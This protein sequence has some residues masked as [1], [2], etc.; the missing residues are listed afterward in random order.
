MSFR[1]RMSIMRNAYALGF[2]IPGFTAVE[3]DH[4]C[5]TFVS[6]VMF[7][8]H[9]SASITEDDSS[10]DD[11]PVSGSPCIHAQ[12]GGSKSKVIKCGIRLV[13][14]Q[15]IED[16][17]ELPAA[18][19]STFHQNHNCSLPKRCTSWHR[20]FMPTKSEY[21]WNIRGNYSCLGYSE[22]DE[23]PDLD[24]KRRR[25]EHSD[26]DKEPEYSDCN[27]RRNYSGSGLD[28]PNLGRP[29]HSD[30]DEEPNLAK[31][32]RTGRVP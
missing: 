31:K 23:E 19:G 7:E 5:L 13:Y 32:S 17:Q 10:S 11:E 29:E 9:N 3:S 8:H 26:R 15:D 27:I 21:H 22:S 18:E 25:P 4:Q 12:F 14:K 20:F 6:R 16:F 2:P 24:R 28:A 30:S 1:M